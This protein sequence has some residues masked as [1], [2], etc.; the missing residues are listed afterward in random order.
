MTIAWRE[1]GRDGGVDV[2]ALASRLNIN[3][4]KSMLIRCTKSDLV[5]LGWGGQ[6][7]D[8]GNVY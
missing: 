5:D 8:Q 6:I 2:F 7:L 1:R 4:R 3:M